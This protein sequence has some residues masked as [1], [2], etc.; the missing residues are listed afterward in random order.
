MLPHAIANR[1]ATL[2][3]QNI[4]ADTI[5]DALITNAPARLRRSFSR[6]LGYLDGS[7]EARAIVEGWL[8]QGGMLAD[9][10]NLGEDER[11]M[12]ANVAPVT[13]DTVLSAIERALQGADEATLKKSTHVTRLL[14]SLAY[15]PAQFDR[16][17]ALLIKFA[18]VADTGEARESEA[19]SIL[20]SLFQIVLSG[21]LAP[22]AMRLKVLQ[23][24]LQ[25]NDAGLRAM[26][27]T[28]LN[29]ML[30]SDGF[31]SSYGFEFGARSR[32]Y[33]YHPHTGR[34]VHDWFDAVMAVA[35]P[36]AL[37]DSPVA[38]EVLN[39][40]AGEF[41]GLWTDALRANDGETSESLKFSLGA[42]DNHRGQRHK[43]EKSGRC[44]RG[45]RGGRP[46]ADRSA[47]PG[48][49]GARDVGSASASDFYG[50]DEASYSGG[51]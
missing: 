10:P 48:G 27:V 24:L 30:R 44:R 23:G 15:D 34:E 28:A 39:S 8:A 1:L 12:L 4:P 25:S 45:W 33:G 21:T 22:V 38:P 50:A 16:A 40:I 7:R 3:L 19:A 37:S 32:D 35:S 41:R 31:S 29:A 20:A 11:A 17:I 18:Q 13:P 42:K 14:R 43:D 36:L 46:E 47:G 51:D 5:T 9:V 2:A 26:G 6:R 49:G